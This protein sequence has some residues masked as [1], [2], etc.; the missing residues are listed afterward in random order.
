MISSIFGDEKSQFPLNVSMLEI[1]KIKNYILNLS[2]K[3]ILVAYKRRPF[4]E[5]NKDIYLNTTL[6]TSVL[7]AGSCYLFRERGR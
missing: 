5:A 7:T 4:R 6:I 1:T 2:E 3:A